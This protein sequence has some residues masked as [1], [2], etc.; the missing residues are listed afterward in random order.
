[1]RA[2][3]PEIEHDREDFWHNPIFEVG[4]RIE[5]Q[6]IEVIVG[7]SMGPFT[8]IIDVIFRADNAESL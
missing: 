8:T 6:S 5:I 1:V 2:N 3:G 4:C 7:T